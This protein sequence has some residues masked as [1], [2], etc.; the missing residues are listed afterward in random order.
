[1]VRVSIEANGVET[2]NNIAFDGLPVVLPGLNA[3]EPS[4]PITLITSMNVI[5][6][7][8]PSGYGLNTYSCAVV[9]KNWQFGFFSL[10][11]PFNS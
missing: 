11:Q 6:E 1:M 8:V 5:S 4:L 9:D 2:F 3:K 7:R 10:D